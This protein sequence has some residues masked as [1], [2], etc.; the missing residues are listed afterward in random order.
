MDMIVSLGGS[1]IIPKDIDTGFLKR[2]K[3]LVLDFTSKGNRVVIVAGGGH[4]ARKYV[5]AAR[6]ISSPEDEDLDWIGIAATKINGELVRSIFGDSAHKEVI[7]NPTE[8]ISS[9]KSI[10]VG[11]GWRPHCSSDMDAVLLAENLG[12]KAVINLSNIEYVYDKDPKKHPDAVP[13]KEISWDK[14][15]S[16][17]GTEWIPSANVPFDPKATQKAKELGLR[18]IL[19]KGTDLENFRNILED[20]DFKGTVI[21]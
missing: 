12:I 18:V 4:T 3:E 5:E 1:I 15:I 17:V 10:I 21:S 2:F 9:D 6:D 11:C 19:A 16:I 20:K 8:K 7:V 13:L 14:M